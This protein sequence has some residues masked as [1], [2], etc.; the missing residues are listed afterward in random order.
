MKSVNRFRTLEEAKKYAL[1]NTRTKQIYIII[2]D[3]ST[4]FDVCCCNTDEDIPLI[5]EKLLDYMQS[6]NKYVVGF[7]YYYNGWNFDCKLFI[8]INY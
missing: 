2:T 5:V 3:N 6:Y 7:A 1:D 4:Y 8:D